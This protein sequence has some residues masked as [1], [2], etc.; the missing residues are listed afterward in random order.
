MRR[1]AADPSFPPE[2]VEQEA[3]PAESICVLLGLL[4]PTAL[5]H[6]YVD[7]GRKC[8]SWRLE[9]QRH[10]RALGCGHRSPLGDDRHHK[11][12]VTG[13][14]LMARAGLRFGVGGSRC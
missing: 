2:S 8:P 7:Q 4:L 10:G 6:R 11:R 9:G 12:I 3:A 13:P 1:T 14:A 5:P